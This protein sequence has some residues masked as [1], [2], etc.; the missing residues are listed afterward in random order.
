[1]HPL[2][3]H[4]RTLLSKGH[5]DKKDIR[6]KRTYGTT[7]NSDADDGAYWLGEE[8]WKGAP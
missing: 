4:Q 5:K 6:T 2:P 7:E 8:L 3:P 1:M